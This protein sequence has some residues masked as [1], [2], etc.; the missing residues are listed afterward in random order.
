MFWF[1][2]FLGLMGC[3]GCCG[4]PCTYYLNKNLAVPDKE[5][6]EKIAP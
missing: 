5:K 4:I 3:C 6:E 1:S 2:F